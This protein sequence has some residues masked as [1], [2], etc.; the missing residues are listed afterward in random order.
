MKIEIRHPNGAER[1][2]EGTEDELAKAVEVIPDFVEG[3]RVPPP[4]STGREL[5]PR[6]QEESPAKRDDGG[7][8]EEGETTPLNPASLDP[9]HLHARFTEVNAT[10]DIERVTVLAQ[11]AVDAGMEGLDYETVSDLYRKLGLR[12]PGKW[13][14]TFSNAQNRG[15]IYSVGRGKWV[16]TPAGYNLAKLGEKQSR[17]RSRPR[18][19][20]QLQASTTTGEGDSG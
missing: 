9:A 17:R 16:T 15:Y 14:S 1:R 3:F 6:R 8:P 2:F 11:A 7:S 4:D 19:G 18:A 5:P 10:T 20:G 13:R 12:M